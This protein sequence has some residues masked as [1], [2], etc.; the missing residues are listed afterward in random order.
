LGFVSIQFGSASSDNPT[1]RELRVK[2]QKQRVS[3]SE[4]SK[5]LVVIAANEEETIRETPASDL[6]REI[7]DTYT[8][9]MIIFS[10]ISFSSICAL[11]EVC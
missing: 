6:L 1:P 8:I 2:K 11:L 3:T 10:T 9:S 4:S 7:C 5:N